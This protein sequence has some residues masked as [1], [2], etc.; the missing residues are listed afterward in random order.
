MGSQNRQRAHLIGVRVTA[1]ERAAIQV[2][3]AE[4]GLGGAAALMR[5]LALGYQPKSILDQRAIRDLVS[6]N[7]DLG[8]LGGLLKRWL[9]D[10]DRRPGLERQRDI[11]RLLRDLDDTQKTI[12][13]LVLKL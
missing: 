6:V 11:A 9:I 1:E 12:K 2:L 13:A 7:A 10:D 8:R 3:A 4:C 5:S